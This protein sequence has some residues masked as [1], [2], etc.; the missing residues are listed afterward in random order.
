M[1]EEFP[2]GKRATARSQFALCLAV[3]LAG[4]GGGPSGGAL[5]PKS[6][7]ASSIARLWWWMM[8]VGFFGLAVVVGMLVTA[9]VRRNKRGIGRDIEGPKAG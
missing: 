4:C 8:G 9:W 2:D 7:Q 5:D 1:K 6:P 3:L